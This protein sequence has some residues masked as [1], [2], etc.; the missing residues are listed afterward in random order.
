MFLFVTFRGSFAPR[1]EGRIG[2]YAPPNPA[3]HFWPPKSE[4]KNRQNQGF[5]F[6]F[7]IGLYQIWDISA[8][9]QVFVI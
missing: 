8:P 3:V 4:P 7:L 9:N 5:G 2:G 1:G 6:L